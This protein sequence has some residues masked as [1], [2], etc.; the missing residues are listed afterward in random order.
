[1]SSHNRGRRRSDPLL[2]KLKSPPLAIDKRE[3]DKIRRG[4]GSLPRICKILRIPGIDSKESIPRNRFL[5]SL[6]K[7]LQIPKNRFLGSL[8]VY[9]LQGIDSCAFL[10]FTNSKESISGLLI[11]LHIRGLWMYT[12]DH[13]V[14]NQNFDDLTQLYI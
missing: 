14:S 11:S 2:L 6:K 13:R 8:K 9:K 3:K 12:A 1:M 4:A 10:K 5:G 7:C